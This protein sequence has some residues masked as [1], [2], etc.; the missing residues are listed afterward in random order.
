MNKRGITINKKDMRPELID[1]S[2]LI[3]ETLP[4]LMGEYKSGK[5]ERRER[6]KRRNRGKQKLKVKKL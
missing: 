4:P 6:R 1:Q 3:L 2:K 5:E